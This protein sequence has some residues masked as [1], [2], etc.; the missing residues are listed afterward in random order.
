MQRKRARQLADEKENKN[1]TKKK[2]QK[3]MSLKARLVLRF[4]FFAVNSQVSAAI[5]H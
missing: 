5:R 2:S 4:N 3:A 1:K